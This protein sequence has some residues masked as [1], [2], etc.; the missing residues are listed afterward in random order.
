M[1]NTKIKQEEYKPD[2]TDIFTELINLRKEILST[3][4]KMKK[5]KNETNEVKKDCT[6]M[7]NELY[8]NKQCYKNGFYGTE[9][10]LINFILENENKQMIDKKMPV[11][12]ELVSVYSKISSIVGDLEI[13]QKGEN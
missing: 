12:I 10:H 8:I 1:E 9:K 3:E 13:E 4:M 5:I 11:L 2:N 7:S 6:A